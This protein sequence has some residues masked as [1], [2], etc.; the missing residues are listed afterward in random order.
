MAERIRGLSIGLDLDS[1]GL[2][3][4]LGTIKR[5]FKDLNSSLKTNM[6]NFKY[7]EKSVDSYKTTI[8]ELDKAMQAQK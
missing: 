3:R 1:T 6:N 4:S 5:S 7:T 8:R 2:D